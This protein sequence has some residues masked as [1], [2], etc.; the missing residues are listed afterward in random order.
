MS[1]K[2]EDRPSSDGEGGEVPAEEPKRGAEG[3]I[4]PGIVLGPPSRRLNP[5][6]LSTLFPFGAVVTF[7]ALLRPPL[8]AARIQ[9]CPAVVGGAPARLAWAS[10]DGA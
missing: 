2:N 3:P 1:K 9:A 6:P 8:H 4:L 7:A 5:G 10:D